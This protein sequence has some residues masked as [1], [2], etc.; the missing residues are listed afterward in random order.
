[1]SD[2]KAENDKLTKSKIWIIS[3]F[4][5]VIAGIITWI[6]ISIMRHVQANREVAGN[7]N[8]L[9]EMLNNGTSEADLVHHSPNSHDYGMEKKM[10]EKC[11]QDLAL[12]YTARDRLA[13][14]SLQRYRENH[15]PSPSPQPSVP[16][17]FSSRGVTLGNWVAFEL[18]ATS[19]NYTTSASPPDQE[20]V[21]LGQAVYFK[22]QEMQEGTTT[23]N[24]AISEDISTGASS[25]DAH[26]FWSAAE[27]NLCIPMGVG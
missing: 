22:C 12:W 6:T 3:I 5:L 8:M 15:P 11:P 14:D 4:A 19:N 17:Y 2:D 18:A 1:M 26:A 13:R 23:L 27:N 9:H 16:A 10:A 25:P 20:F 21:Q 7:C 24:G